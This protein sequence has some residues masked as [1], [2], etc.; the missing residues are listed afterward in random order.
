MH[1]CTE[2]QAVCRGCGQLLGGSP[3]WRGGTA[4]VTNDKGGY[5]RSVKRNY[6]GGWVCSRSCDYRASLELEQSMPG[7]GH[8]Q[9]RPGREAMDR[10]NSNWPEGE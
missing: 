2:T 9:Q 5:V 3:Y 8:S 1:S 4:Y 6:F 10:I 7:H